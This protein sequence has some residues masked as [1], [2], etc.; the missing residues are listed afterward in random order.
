[1]QKRE[2]PI[3]CSLEHTLLL[4]SL[5]FLVTIGRRIEIEQMK[6]EQAS[7]Q[8]D[9]GSAVNNQVGAKTQLSGLITSVQGAAFQEFLCDIHDFA[10]LNFR[11]LRFAE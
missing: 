4:R 1:M 2:G 5:Y 8:P 9:K 3:S 10:I 7:S 6:I 11:D